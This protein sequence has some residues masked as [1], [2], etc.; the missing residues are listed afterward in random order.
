MTFLIFSVLAIFCTL[1]AVLSSLTNRGKGYWL[2]LLLSGFVLS[3]LWVL[4]TKISK[5][6]LRDALIWDVVIGTVFT[7]VL[8]TLGHSVNFSLKHWIGVVATFFVF[9]YW[10]I[11]K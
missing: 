7:L 2:I 6:L 5:N 10:S 11:I 1:Q 3:G 9:L 4:I 8:V